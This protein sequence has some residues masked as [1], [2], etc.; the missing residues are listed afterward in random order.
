M[1]LTSRQVIKHEDGMEHKETYCHGH[2]YGPAAFPH[3]YGTSDP[4]E[5]SDYCEMVDR[6]AIY[7]ETGLEPEQIEALQQENDGWQ[8]RYGELDTGHSK[9]FKDFCGM[10]QENERLQDQNI[11]IKNWNACEAEQFGEL[12]ESD[13]R[14]IEL[15]DEVEQL[16]AQN[17]VMAEALK[18]IVKQ[19]TTDFTKFELAH[20]F[21]CPRERVVLEY[22]QDALTAIDKAG[23]GENG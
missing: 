19:Y 6:L 17:G 7:E 11:S 9:L 5:Y 15:E 18:N 12:L 20:D 14:R 3:K 16:Q 22:A 13:K 1:R 8:K 21:L 4:Q 2:R 10:K 23:G